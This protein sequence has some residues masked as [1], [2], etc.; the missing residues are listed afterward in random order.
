MILDFPYDDKAY[1][2]IAWGKVT[3]GRYAKTM[4][5]VEVETMKDG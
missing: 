3:G 2:C 4:N 5:P 1:G